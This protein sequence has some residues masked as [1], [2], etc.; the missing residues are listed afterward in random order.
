MKLFLLIYTIFTISLVDAESP[1]II[2]EKNKYLSKIMYTLFGQNATEFVSTSRH[3]HKRPYVLYLM[4]YDVFGSIT[5][6]THGAAQRCFGCGAR[7]DFAADFVQ[8]C[9]QSEYRA[10]F[11]TA[12][13]GFASVYAADPAGGG[14][15]GSIV[16]SVGGDAVYVPRIYAV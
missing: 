11:R 2:T 15:V 9:S 4:L 1:T 5:A 13:L 3:P 12:R 10:V 16:V 14:R 7:Y 6:G 8:A